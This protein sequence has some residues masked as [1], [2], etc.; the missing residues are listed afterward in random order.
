MS[1]ARTAEDG[2]DTFPD[3]P[4]WAG[5]VLD[6]VLDRVAVTRAEVGDRFPLFADPAGGRWTTSGRGSWTGGFWA[7]L[8]WLRARHTGRATDREAA[9]RCTSRLAHW[10][11]ADTATRGL[12]F[13]YGTALADTPESAA[14]RARAAHACRDAYDAELG[15]L[16]WGS[17]FGGPRLLARVDGVPG[18]VPL[19]ASVDPQTAASHLRRHLELCLGAGTLPAR[20]A[21]PGQDPAPARDP[22]PGQHPTPA[23]DPLPGQD[24]APRQSSS[25]CWSWWYERPGRW[26]PCDDPPSGWS[27]GRPWLLLAVADAAHRLGHDDLADHVRQLSPACV[28]PAADDGRPECPLDT[29]AAAIN[30]VALLKLGHRDQAV[31]LLYQLVRTHV[32]DDGRLL[33]GCYDLASGTATR[34]ELVWGDFFLAYALAALTGLV[35]VHEA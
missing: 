35:D 8:L 32:T 30:A 14:L 26:I 28:V 23:R 11:D 33:N 5:P 15:L 13:W 6:S 2:I 9:A 7:G 12:I 21:A 22:A 34:H 24:P 18:T 3:V 1:P 31:A 17:A 27:R 10:V 19:L 20:G 16:P 29:S 4:H 25:L